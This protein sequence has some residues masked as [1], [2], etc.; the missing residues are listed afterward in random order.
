MVAGVTETVAGVT[1]T[2]AG[3]MEPVAGVMETV[4]GET[5]P[6]RHLTRKRK[7]LMEMYYVSMARSVSVYGARSRTMVFFNVHW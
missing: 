6:N 7:M 1:E 5:T 2:V 4:A 3:V